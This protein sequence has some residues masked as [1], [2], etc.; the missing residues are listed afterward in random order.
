MQ[1]TENILS[2]LENSPEEQILEIKTKLNL[3]H[4][5]NA[6]IMLHVLENNPEK[7][8]ESLIREI[9][10][11]EKKI[12]KEYKKMQRK[13]DSFNNEFSADNQNKIRSLKE[14]MQELK[15]FI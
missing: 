15:A 8:T 5:R 10:K 13:I 7:Y 9:N 14:E 1:I 12:Q 6:R 4:E 11:L 2:K 3:K